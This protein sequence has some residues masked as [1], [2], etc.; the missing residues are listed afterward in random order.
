M[1]VC[2]VMTVCASSVAAHIIYQRASG[3][4]VHKCLSM[5]ERIPLASVTQS[6]TVGLG[7]GWGDW[8]STSN[9]RGMG[10]AHLHKN[11]LTLKKH[12]QWLTCISAFHNLTPLYCNELYKRNEGAGKLIQRKQQRREGLSDAVEDRVVLLP[13]TPSLVSFCVMRIPLPAFRPL[14]INPSHQYTAFCPPSSNS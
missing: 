1:C 11:L 5:S 3:V 7:V 4:C 10:Q 8:Q 13:T 6:H 9:Y 12:V 2:V 14:Q